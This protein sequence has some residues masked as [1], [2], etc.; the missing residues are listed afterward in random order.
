MHSASRRGVHA[1]RGATT[2]ASV[3]L[4]EQAAH[5]GG[6]AVELYSASQTV[7]GVQEIAPGE[8][9]KPSPDVQ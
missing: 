3:P 8:D 7:Q 2:H 1:Q 4:V 9:E 5:S 6:M